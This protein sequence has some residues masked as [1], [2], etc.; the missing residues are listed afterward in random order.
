MQFGNRIGGM[1]TIPAGMTPVIRTGLRAQLALPGPVLGKM[2]DELPY[3]AELLTPDQRFLASFLGKAGAE[4]VEGIPVE[5]QREQ[6]DGS[7]AVVGARVVTRGLTVTE[8]EV[9]GAE[10]SLRMRLYRPDSLGTARGRCSSGST[11]AVGS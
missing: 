5:L 1:D 10:G 11:E 2:T 9:A 3:G 7:A 8:H 4:S 6:T